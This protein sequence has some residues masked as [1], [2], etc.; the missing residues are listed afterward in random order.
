MEEIRALNVEELEKWLDFVA[1][2]F[3]ERVGLNI[4]LFFFLGITFKVRSF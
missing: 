4:F 2:C 1:A 3:A